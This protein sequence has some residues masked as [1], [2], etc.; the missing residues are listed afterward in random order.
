MGPLALSAAMSVAH[1]V[2]TGLPTQGVCLVGP[3][4]KRKVFFFS[5]AFC[6]Y[7]GHLPLVPVFF[8]LRGDHSGIHRINLH[9]A[10]C[11]G[12]VQGQLA[13][14]CQVFRTLSSVPSTKWLS[15]SCAPTTEGVTAVS[16]VLWL[17]AG[18]EN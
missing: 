18:S 16:R 3:M 1:V 8:F 10:G 17:R 2:A 4:V 15:K 14:G 6:T 7:L 11:I 5:G 9:G 12:G 13:A